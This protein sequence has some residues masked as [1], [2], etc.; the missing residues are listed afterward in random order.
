MLEFKY[1]TFFFTLYFKFN[2]Q[3]KQSTDYGLRLDQAEY[4]TGCG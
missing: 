3:D 1:S 4:G 2:E